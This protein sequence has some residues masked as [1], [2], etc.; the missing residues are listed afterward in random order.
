MRPTT[1]HTPASSADSGRVVLLDRDGVIIA[2]RPGYVLN[3]DQVSFIPG[4]KAALRMLNRRGYTVHVVSNQSAV[5][6]GLMSAEELDEITRRMIE[7]VRRSG[8]DIKSV[9]YC[10]HRPEENCDC[11]KPKTGLLKSVADKFNFD[12]KKVWLV[13]DRHTDAEAGNAVGCRTIL[14]K[15]GVSPDAEDLQPHKPLPQH[16]EPHQIPYLVAEDLLDAV[17]LIFREDDTPD[18]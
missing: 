4:S 3:C 17:R 13:G 12:V 18:D 7:D 2:D 15:S 5:G 16:A 10:T 8:G 1:G 9:H 6:R 14:V 11:R